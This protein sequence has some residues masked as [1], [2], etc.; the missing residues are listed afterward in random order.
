MP[1]RSPCWKNHSRKKLTRFAADEGFSPDDV[2]GIA[3][4]GHPMTEPTVGPETGAATFADLLRARAAERPE[5]VAFTFLTD[6]EAEGASLTYG[7]LDRRARAIAAALAESVAPGERALLLYPPGLDFI[8]A[9]FGCLYAGVV[10][11][12]AYPPRPNDRSQSRL[13]AI[14]R[15]ATPRAALTTG[16]IL[17]GAAGPRGL[18][19]VAPELA[20]PR[21]IATDG[22]LAAGVVLAEGEPDPEWVAFLQYTS[23]STAT[24]KGVMV[25]HA[26]LLH[27]ERMIGAAFGMDE[28]S[29]VVGWLPL[30]HD[31]GLIGNVLQPL[32]AGARCV[33]M[34]PVAFLQRPMRWLEAI[35]RYR[36]TVSGGPNFA[37]ELCLRKAAPEAVAGLDLSSWRVAFNGAEPV[38]A[39]TLERFAATFAPSGFRPE[40][41]YPCYGLAEATLFVTGGQPGVAPR[42]DGESGRVSC[43]RSWMGQR[44]VVADPETGSEVP[45]GSIGE[46]WIAGPS[47]ARGYWRNPGATAHD[48]NAFLTGADGRHEGPFLRTGDLG[49]LA[50]GELYVTGRLKDLIILRGRNHYPQDVELTAEGAHPDLRP[51]GGAAFAVEMG[52]EERLVVVHEVERRRRAPE[53]L[54][55]NVEEIAEALR[56]AVAAEHEVQVH[57][58]VLIRQ[59]SLPKTSSGKVQRRLCRD[60]Y[61]R[62]ELTVEGRSALALAD[63][64]PEIA[65][66][67]IRGDL[68]ALP[69]VE[70]RGMLAAYLRERA[71]AVLGVAASAISSQPLTALG[72]DSLTAVELKGS[73]E[74]ALGAPVPLADLLQGI[75]VEELADRVLAGWEEDAAEVPAPRA[76]SLTGDQPL[77]AGQR[78]L[79]FLE[80][81]APEAGTYNV[82]VAARARGG[83]DA[84]ALRRAL[85]GLME[86]HEALRTVIRESDGEPLQ[87]AAGGLEPDVA[88]VDARGWSGEELRARMAREAWRPFDLAAGPLLRARIYETGE[89]SALLFAVHHLVSDFWSLAL[90]ARELGALYLQETGGPRAELPP[91]PL[92]YSDF[93]HWQREIPPRGL[94]YWLEALAGLPDL[95]LPT[96]RP[97]PAAQTWRGLARGAELPAGLAGALRELASAEGAT[98]FAAL[99]AAFQAQLGRYAG[100]QDFAVGT[101]TAGRGAPEWAGVFGYFVNPVALRAGLAGDPAFREL[102]GRARRTSLAGLEHAGVPFVT[103]AERLRPQRDPARPPLFQ[104]MLALQQRRPGDDPGLPVFALGE[105]GARI[106]LGP[107]EL[108]SVGLPE[109]RAQFEIAL[110]AAELPSGGLGLSIEVN[111]DLFDGATAERMLGHFRTLI[112][113]AVAEPDRRLSDLPLLTPAEREE[114]RSDWRST[115]EPSGPVPALSL[116]E[117]VLERAR[118]DPGALAVQEELT[119]GELIDRAGGLAAHLRRLGVGPEMPV[120]LC[121]ERSA[122]LVVGALGILQ[123]GGVYLP[124]E[125]GAS[126]ARLAFILEDAGAAA[127]VTQRRVALP[128][129]AV[130]VL[131]LEDVPAVPAVP[132]V[133]LVPENL[134]YLIYTSGSTG[135]PKGVAVTHGAA[136]E[137][138]LTWARAYGMTG[139]DRVLQ[140]PSAGFDA[141]V[142]Q[143]F[144]ALLSGATLVLRGPEMWGP[145]ELTQKIADLALTIIDL[146]TAFFSRWVQDAGDLGAPP[147][148]RLIG[149]Y[150][151]ELRAET[152]RRWSRTPLARIP[153]L[154]CYGPTE[155]VVSA[156]LHAVRPEEGEAGPV[157]IGRALPGR[158][159]RVLD[160]QG[161][162]R[163]V[164]LPG[165]LVLSGPLARGYLGRPDL[166]A[167]VFVPDPFG[168]PGGRMYRSGDLARRRADGAIEFLGR[169]DDQVKVRGFRVEPGEVEAV[170][171]AHPGVREATVLA[172]NPLGLEGERRLVAF[173]SPEIPEDL[174]GFLRERL[175]DYMLPAAWTALPALPLNANG[176]VDRDALALRAGEAVPLEAAGEAAPRTPEEELLAGIWAELLGRERVGIHDDF[177]ALG[178]HSLLATRAVARVARAF[179]VDLPVSALFQTPTVAGLAGRIAGAEKMPPVRPLGREPGEAVPLSFAQRRLWFLEQLEPGSA[180]YN[181]PGEVRLEGPLDVAALAAALGEVVGR[182][183]ALRTVFVADRGEPVQRVEP[184]A[185]VPLP[186]IDLSSL[187]E[188]ARAAEAERRA[189]AE[190]RRP[191]DLAHGPVRRALLLRLAPGD[192]RLAVTFHHIVSDDWSLDLFLEELAALYGGVIAGVAGEAPVLPVLP[193]QYADFAAWQREWLEGG[194]LERQLG[195]WR[196]R[197]AGLPV[198][199]LPADRP[200]PAV[201]DP[202][203]A[204]RSLAIPRETAE[205]VTRLARREGITLFMALLGVF[206]ALLARVTGE[207]AI[208]VGSPVANRRRPEVER[209]IG[210]FVNTLVLDVRVG[211]DPSLSGLLAR[212]R[213]AALGAYAHQDLPFERLVEEL[214]PTRDLSQN[215]LFQV[216]LVLE[217]P[218]PGRRAG[219]LALEPVRRDSGT[220]KF[221]LVLAVSPRADGGW[222]AFAEHSTA[223]YDGATVERLLG[224]WR[225]LL[226]GA[227]AMDPET[228]LSRLPLLTEGER[229]QIQAEWN[230]TRADFP[231]GLRLH[232]LFAAQAAR[233]PGAVAVVGERERVTYGE[234]A[235]RVEGIARFLRDLGV[236]PEVRVGL[237]LERTPEMLAGILGILRAGGAYVPLDPA[238]PQERLELMLGDSGAEL[239]VTQSSLAGRFDFFAG[240]IVRLD[241]EEPRIAAAPDI[242]GLEADPDNLAYVIYTSGSTGRPKGVAIAH[243]SAVSLVQWGLREFPRD[244]LE[245]SLAATSICFDISIFELFAP[246]A[247]GGKV[248]LAPTIVGLPELAATAE[249]T[250][251]NAVPSPMAEL[252]GHRLPEGLRIVNLGG[253]AL[254]ADLVERIYANPQVERVYNLYGPSE[255]TTYSTFARVPKGASLV[256]IGRPVAGTQVRVLGRHGEPVPVGVHGELFLSGAGLARGYLGRPDLTADRFV[257]DPFGPPGARMYRTGDRVRLLPDGELDFLGRFD[258]QVKLHGM[259]MELGEIEAAL[260]E[261]PAVRQGVAALRADGPEGARLVGYL[262]PEEERT[263]PEVLT[264]GVAAF[265][266]A[267]LPGLMVPT[268]WVVLDA[269]P[270][271]PNGKVDRRALPA[272]VRAKAAALVEPRSSAEET[273]AALWRELLGLERIGVHDDFFE[274][275]GHS[276]LAVRA[277]FRAGEAFGMEVPVAA[278]FQAPTIAELAVWLER[279][280]SRA[281]LSPVASGESEHPPLS[282]AQHRFWF[283][284]RL[285]PG[286][287]LYNLQ[288]VVRLE[289]D[290]DVHELGRA[291]A[292]IVRRHE[293]LRTVYPDLDGEPFQRVLPPESAPPLARLSLAALPAEL[294][295]P[296]ADAAMWASAEGSFDLRRGPVARFLLIET[297]PGDRLLCA[298]FHHIATDGWSLGIFAHELAALY[299]TYATGRPSPLPPLP[300]RYVDVAAAERRDLDSPSRLGYWREQLAGL[301]PLDLPADRPRSSAPGPRATSRRID[302]PPGLAESLRGPGY[303]PF[304]VLLGGFAALLSRLSGQEDFGVGVPT[305]GRS[306]PE[307][308]G[309]IGL[310]VNTLVLRTPMGGDPSFLDLLQR[311]REV[312][313]AAQVHQDVP[314]DRLIEDLQPERGGGLTPLFQV[315]FTYLSD[316]ETPLRMP[317]VSATLLEL[318][319]QMTQFDLTLWLHEWEGRQHG[320]LSFRADLFEPATAE[321]FTR[322]LR[323]LLA[324]AVATPGLRLSELPLLTEEERAELLVDWNDTWAAYPSESIAALFSRKA[325][326]NPAAPVLEM[327]DERIPY[328][329]LDRRSSRLA[330]HLGAL[331]AGPGE[332]VAVALPRSFELIE[333]I[334]AVLKTGAAY[335]PL[336]PGHPAER[337]ERLRAQAGARLVVDRELLAR[338]REAIGR[339]SAAPLPGPAGPGD[340]A[341]VMYTSGST[342]KPKGVAVTHRGV[343]RLVHGGGF[344]R[345]GPGEVFL[346]LAPASFDASTLEIWGALL[347]GAL[348][349]VF[350][351]EIPTPETLARA[352]R[353]HGVTALWL[354]AGLFHLVAEGDLSGFRS[355][356]QLLAGGDVLS[357]AHV[358]RALAR[359]PGLTLINGYGPTEGTTFTCCHPMTGLDPGAGPVPIGR[360]IGNTRVHV[361]D[362]GLSL[363]PVGVPGELLIGGDG[364]ALGYLHQ[365]ALT[366]E[367]F[368]PDPFSR[369]GE[370]L[371]RSG[372]RVRWRADGTLEFLGRIDRQVKIRGFRVEP[373]EV[374]AELAGHPAVAAVAVAA[375]RR[376]GEARLVAWVAPAPGEEGIAGRLRE[377]LGRRLP[378]FLVPS[379]ILEIDSLPLTPNGKVDLR[380]LPRPWEEA[381]ETVPGG[382]PASPEAELLAG[383]FAELLGREHVGADEDFFDLGGHSLL[384]TQLA[385]RVRALFGVELP[386]AEI[387]EHPTPA[388]LAERLAAARRAALPGAEPPPLVREGRG[389]APL[390]FSQQRLWFLHQLDPEDAYQVP[391]ALRLRGVLNASALEGALVEI[392]RRHES[393]RTVFRV[394]D[395]E[396]VQVVLPPSPWRLP[397][398]DLSALPGEEREREAAR[399][400]DREARRPFSLERGPVARFLLVRLADGDQLLAMAMHHIVSD[401]WSLGVLLRELGALYGSLTAG[402]PSPLPELAIQY[403][404]FARWQRRWLAGETLARELA[405]WRRVLAGAPETLDLPYDRP[406]A[407]GVSNRGGRLPFELPPALW[408]DLLELSGRDGW[409]PFMAVLAGFQALLA[410]YGG[411]EDVVVG[412][413]IANRNRFELEGLIGFFTNTLALRLDLS[414]DPG[415]LEIGRRARA[416]ALDAYSHQDLPFEKLVEELAPDR[417]LGRNPLF[418]TLLVLQKLPAPPVLPG[419]AAELL[420]P[421]PGTAKFDLALLLV[422]ADGRA[423]GSLEYARDLFDEA[424]AGRLLGHLRTL[425]EGAARDPGLRLSELPLL[426]AAE[427]EE[428]LAWNR[429]LVPEPPALLVHERVAEQAAH[430]PEALAVTGLGEDLTYGEL[431]ARSR[432]LARRLRAL[433]VGPDVV[434]GLFLERS[435]DQMAAVLG[436][437]EAGGACLPLDPS[438][439]AERLRL[440]LEDA[441]APVLVTHAPLAGSVPPGVERVVLM[442]EPGDEGEEPLP[443]SGA[444]P[445]HL[446]YVIYTSGSTGRPKGVALTHRALSALLLWQLR[447][448]AFGS[449]RTLQ[450]TS[451]SFDV[452]FQEIFSTWWAGG[453]VVLVSEETRRDPAA[454]VRWMAERRVE[455]LFLPFVALQQIAV[456]AL[457][458][459][460]GF[461]AGLREVMSAGEQLH[462]TPQV[463]ELFSRLPGA[464]LYNHYGPAETHVVTWLALAGDPLAWPERPAIGG[465]VDHARVHLLDAGMQPVPVGVVGEIWVSGACLGRGY[466]GRPGLTAERFLPDP[467]AEGEPDG[468]LYRTGDLARRRPDGVL[469]YLGRRDGQ[470]KIRGHRIELFEVEAA[471]A[472]HPAVRQAA[473]AVHGAGQGDHRAGARRL[474]ACVVP[475]DEAA[476]PSPAELRD[477]LAASLPAPMIPSAWARVSSLP[478]TATGK[479]DRRALS[480]IEPEEGSE[481]GGERVA[482]RD[483]AE[484]LMA[485]IWREVL[486]ISRVGVHD[487]FF[488]LGGHSLLAT[489]VASR[490]RGA[491][492]VELPLRR[493]FEA[494]TLAAMTAAALDAERGGAAPPSLHREPRPASL[495]LSFAQERLW[496]L[497]LL[498]PES[499]AYNIPLALHA[500][501][502]LDPGRLA[503]VLSEVVRRHEILR[504]V[505]AEREGVPEQ[506]V[507]PPAGVPLPRID[508]GGLPAEPREAEARRIAAEDAARPFDLRRGPLL[509]CLLL[510]LAPESSTLVLNLHHIV[511]DGW[512]MGV[513][514]REV[515]ALYGG[516]PLPELQVQY[517]DFALWQRRWLS[518]GILEGQIAWWRERLRGAAAV[519]ELPADHPRPPVLSQRGAE[520][521]FSLEGELGRGIAGLARREEVTPFMVLA[522]GLFALLSRLTGQ[523]D[524]TVGSPIA[525][526]NR[527]ET[528]GLIGFFVNTLVLR[529][530]LSRAGSFRDLLLQ[531]RD[532]SLG[533]FAHQDLPFE[534]LVDELQ[535][536]RDLSRSPLF[537]VAMALQNTPLPET[538]LEGVRMLPEEISA[539]IAKFDL[540]FVFMGAPEERLRGLLQYAT[541]L[542]EPPTAARFARGFTTLLAELV[543]R[544]RRRL[545]EASLLDEGERHQVLLEWNDTREPF[546]EGATL[547]GLFEQRAA[548]QPDALAVVWEGEALTYGELDGRS[549]RLAG[550]LRDLGAGPG[551]PVAIWMERSPDLVVAALAVLRAGGHYL[552]LDPSWPAERAETILALSGTPVLLTRAALLPAARD[553]QW[554]LPLADVVCLDVGTPRP[555]P[556]PVAAGEVRALWDFVAERAT[557]RVTAGGFLSSYTGLP[558]SEAEVDEYRDRVLALAAPWLRPDARVLEIGCGAGLLFWEMAPRVAHAVGLD[559]SERTQERNRERARELGLENVELPTGFAHE[560]GALPE[561]AFDLVLIAST[562]QFFPGPEYL[563]RVVEEA[564]ARLAPGGALLI[565]DVP[566]ARRQ[567]EF[568]RS[569]AEAGAGTAPDRMR[570]LDE[571]LFR[572]LGGEILHRERGF[573][574]ELRFRYDVLIPKD[575]ADRSIPRGRRVWTGWHVGRQPGAVSVAVPPEAFAYVIHTS[576]STGQPKG[577]GVQHR[578]AVNLVRWVNG[579]FRIGPDDRLLFVT[580]LGFDLSVYD[581]FGTLAAGGTI[582][583]AP[584]EALRDPGRLAAMLRDPAVT[585]WDSAPAALQQLAPLFP[586]TPDPAGRLRLVLLSGDWIPVP[587]PDQVRAAFPGSRVVSFG[588]ATEGTVWSNWYPIGEVDPRWPSIPYGRPLANNRYYALDADLSPCPIGVPGDLYIAGDVLSVGYVYQPELTAAQFLPDPF[589]GRNGARMYRTGDRGRYGADGNLEFLGRVDHQVKVRGY[590]IELGEIESALLHHPQVREA[591]VLAREDVPGEKSLVAYLVPARKPAPAV[592]ELRAFLRETLPEYMV[593]W[594]FVELPALPVTANGKLDRDALPAPREVRAAGAPGKAGAYEAPRNDLERTISEVWREVLQ[595]DRVGVRESFFEVGGSS[596]LMGRVQSRLSRAI[597]REVPFVDLFRHPTIESLARSLEGGAPA[598]GEK[599][600]AARARTETRR[601]SLRQLQQMRGQRRGRKGEG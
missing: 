204:V 279:A 395:E 356:R 166:T 86:R 155:T 283:L 330:R 326:E 36:G 191:F 537:Q 432:R 165:E 450:F 377:E 565:A 277:A 318:A 261:H 15:D 89:G 490:I 435:A 235:A 143:I 418:Q 198:L 200:R 64:A 284:D 314:F 575:A 320:W 75:G 106:A 19:A 507:L 117:L 124:L 196:G 45:A 540:S 67:L 376:G 503:A 292:E 455:R 438:Y 80:R 294:R 364:L 145:R 423:T 287:P 188:G 401:A 516:L 559:P 442:E 581:L 227:A 545:A 11:V 331:G 278:L 189:R 68:A 268:A 555:E 319:P 225:T 146:P 457:A 218:L 452:S 38:R 485:E 594:A 197:L 346:Q 101:P 350:P 585:V 580:S 211:D 467:F 578:A 263:D 160:F 534:R 62:G 469:E 383:L 355:L 374:E 371:Y 554:R 25:T 20:G 316:P 141:S 302:L 501:G 301:P 521:L 46:V 541:D 573:E 5:Q 37:Y 392:V 103:L 133:P 528:E 258:H 116:Y 538:G 42:V 419:V 472:R 552:P 214:A 184:A 484:E 582:Q 72:L 111:A 206:Q 154:N 588:G 413:P 566:D 238:Y 415:F 139:R 247:M 234:L 59:G 370:R 229:Q 463:A 41:F 251:V 570:W 195:Y 317:G 185:A 372:D 87:R 441:G 535:P 483:A 599:A 276:L 321:R 398:A 465:P 136:V 272:P 4:E 228:P 99:L 300:L 313:V 497:H 553:L 520:H 24:P 397:V 512:S 367:R 529:A 181:V 299:E 226:E 504:T 208:P 94:E 232:D 126:A 187:P 265:L 98:L 219:G 459:C 454:L 169:L 424:T 592:P 542:F 142:E 149:T 201:R 488:E 357:P 304:M 408:A 270:L 242:P 193:V 394:Q 215:P 473:V 464:V 182:H 396:P 256:T 202:R 28:T 151:E 466:L 556:E 71:A 83:L 513:L 446:V 144:S 400:L 343:V 443:P 462:V 429:P 76:L 53:A 514:V 381:G 399:L 282:S 47:V 123:A 84:G 49:Y 21:W 224:Q 199:E 576:G 447:T 584:E 158:V 439:P 358:A 544:P 81:L 95:D 73:M 579:T 173:V 387:F 332:I 596:L 406:P 340:L 411:Q 530:D 163:P 489:Q 205:A 212:V 536:Q 421:D 353:R 110:N 494:S 107:L 97:R 322:H 303:T 510:E 368:I 437:L 502:P 30:Y 550:L 44:I 252:A 600:E 409:T 241:E 564:L 79:W 334:L 274:L 597:G 327:G 85:G 78:A 315:L 171:T 96:D 254:K 296:A 174:P 63:P 176:K 240:R 112:A 92:R 468:R 527:L 60:L 380:A 178:G 558:F 562:V 362:P 431:L 243:R 470:V 137:H 281:A 289:G 525:N 3:R 223:L 273:L 328:G 179:G 335:L 590:R 285:Q 74:A 194:E 506:I 93:V 114:L 471:L 121:V 295:G 40:A 481:G 524:L 563:E 230:D 495:P 17:A 363:V 9:F 487:D 159:A 486:G 308:Q 325:A 293:P 496:F 428:L 88:V 551:T 7:E 351:P 474:V 412:S 167:E 451:L 388:T 517:A 245:G 82:A 207:T 203:G 526:R 26:N 519:L 70:R 156:T 260:E 1:K 546:E 286:N 341:Y 131:F 210:L 2:Q 192:H 147:S 14:A 391:G 505:F 405:H 403:A 336:D 456:A 589:A 65:S 248:I 10:A 386:L 478:L 591:V 257:P 338:D 492:G 152:V 216:V 269:F 375:E 547:H 427:R 361:V 378:A 91:V 61:L 306:R 164:G 586:E 479:L 27:N 69:P 250:I 271:S 172:L 221:D 6:G 162:P 183:E 190:A 12:P 237:C 482:P 113:A 23:G 460:A 414:G 52:G 119:Y 48:F 57:D 417:Q 572:D 574:N 359:L 587:L 382:V 100:Q 129:T 34:S 217:E 236:G 290:L 433:G 422:E 13:R 213:E 407:A 312:T 366:A 522:A 128:E 264:S 499:S 539:G 420:D 531:V 347:H 453:A 583:V 426:T 259:R 569:L 102:L 280:G 291:L 31:M 365:P 233:S 434:V 543:A 33:L 288:V 549:T 523:P 337:R 571:D 105:D 140:F 148:L 55:G 477:F 307:T 168:S 244:V 311:V 509:R 130:P 153:L 186:V 43:G 440:M 35:A 134:A 416:A 161:H 32:H 108:E 560:I 515:Q 177:F 476:P 120:A 352:V 557:D 369:T 480:R 222:D 458:G 231:Q 16:A 436:V 344:A 561:G 56:R 54:E 115:A 577:I 598:P 309:M 342:G 135:R 157:P 508:L 384:A 393:L 29:V 373:A 333:A 518:G 77:S 425:F 532:A 170:L 298:A 104:A 305:A 329:E 498:Q 601:E 548:L 275:G 402:E 220:A 379:E 50:G 125:P 66:A 339:A 209:L 51:G 493:L 253:E 448:S 354:T 323:T 175:P 390:S 8:A 118:R 360:P 444:L 430:D 262:V 593:P 410:R 404:D 180:V 239:L 18:L 297:A 349:A 267:R 150:G 500:E 266:R 533:A 122:D 445:D 246:L 127:L 255:D 310:F 39:S 568:R 389:T 511:T 449:G 475:R 109:R 249:V 595:L 132:A 491:F 90:G 461:P 567:A 385:S 58:V 22:P 348:L 138:C 324:A 345:F